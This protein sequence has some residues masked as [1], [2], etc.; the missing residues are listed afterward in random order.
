MSDRSLKALGYAQDRLLGYMDEM[1]DTA[2]SSLGAID[3][4]ETAWRWA[5]I[6]LALREVA[7]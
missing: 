4:T 2:D 5:I 6:V 3:Y 7:R 1:R